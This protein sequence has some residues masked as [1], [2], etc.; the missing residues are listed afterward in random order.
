MPPLVVLPRLSFLSN[1]V[2]SE[3]KER[4]PWVVAL[5]VMPGSGASARDGEKLEMTE[6]LTNGRAGMERALEKQ[7]LREEKEVGARVKHH[8][9]QGNGEEP[10]SS[11]ESA[12]LRTLPRQEMVDDTLEE[13]D[14]E[15]ENVSTP[16]IS[17]IP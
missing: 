2:T 13:V 6:E 16:P 4:C 12:K 11:D 14:L 5:K 10:D 7:G 1:P 8:A 15:L 9:V 3:Q 17:T